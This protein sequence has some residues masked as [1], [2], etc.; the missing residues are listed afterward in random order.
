MLKNNEPYRYA[1]P[2]TA[3]AKLAEASRKAGRGTAGQGR[4][5]GRRAEPGSALNEVYLKEGLPRAR[6]PEQ[7]PAGERR[8][9]EQAEVVS[10]VEEVHRPRDRGRKNEPAGTLPK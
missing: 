1:K 8:I 5:A 3:K 4:I 2:Q 6:T 10:F 9:L 7:L